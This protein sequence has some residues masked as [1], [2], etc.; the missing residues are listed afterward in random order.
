MHQVRRVAREPERTATGFVVR[1]LLITSASVGGL[2]LVPQF[3]GWV[4]G[5]TIASFRPLVPLLPGTP[6][7][8]G[9]FVVWA[10]ASLEIIQECTSLLPTLLLASAM[11]AA[12]APIRM[13]LAG[14]V[15][16]AAVLWIYNLL[17]L[18]AAATVLY[19]FPSAFE[20][21]HVIIWQGATL[22]FVVA[23]FAGWLQFAL[24]TGPR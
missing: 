3:G 16:A 15:T 11:L 18:Y 8:R 23:L 5:R 20:F 14:I 13:K 12:P 10:T 19:L 6:I 2:A 9:P 24:R 21:V 22:F 17:R 7:I 4:L 1:G